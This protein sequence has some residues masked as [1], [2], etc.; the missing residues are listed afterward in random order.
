MGLPYLACMTDDALNNLVLRMAAT[1]RAAFAAFYSAAA[2]KLFGLLI[3]ILGT[4]T[5]AEDAM[6]EV[7]T[8][9]WLR[10]AQFDPAKG[11]AMAWAI[12]I[13]RNHAIDLIRA[14]KKGHIGDDEAIATL[15]DPA[16]RA[17]TR[18]MAQGELSRINQCLARLDPAVE[19]ALR[20]AY[21]D[22]KSYS[23]LA[24][25]ANVPLNTLRTWLRRGLISLKDCMMP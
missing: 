22:G 15:A 2:P 20:G 7:F 1:D 19:T 3:R 23:D 10:A 5:E 13:A 25:A 16:P 14:R 17:E 18:L 24:I 8:R 9:I 6:Q 21:L 4:K 11:G 12:T